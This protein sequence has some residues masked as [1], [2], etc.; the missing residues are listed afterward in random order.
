MWHVQMFPI[1]QHL[2]AEAQSWQDD[3]APTLFPRGKG[4]DGP[5]F[6]FLHPRGGTQMGPLRGGHGHPDGLG[7][8]VSSD[9]AQ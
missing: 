7:L 4:V 9:H 8:R 3:V 5:S 2:P 1:G 6:H